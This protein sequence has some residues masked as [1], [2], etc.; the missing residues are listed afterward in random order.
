MQGESLMV[1]LR[2]AQCSAHPCTPI[3]SPGAEAVP[4]LALAVTLRRKTVG[5]PGGLRPPESYFP[6]ALCAAIDSSNSTMRCRSGVPLGRPFSRQVA[7]SFL[8]SDSSAFRYR[9]AISTP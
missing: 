9:S 7:H 5:G 3:M 8:R 1:A 2:E 6:F 4:G